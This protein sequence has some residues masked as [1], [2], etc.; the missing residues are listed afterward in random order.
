MLYQDFLYAIQKRNPTY[1]DT[2]LTQSVSHLPA[3]Y[4]TTLRTF[5]KYQKQ[6]HHVLNYFY[7]NGQLECLNNHIN[8]L[9]RNAYGFYNF[10]NFKLRIFVQQGQAI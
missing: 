1:F 7:S 5:E 8:V 2:L 6:I 3:T 9:K 4:Q 10:Y